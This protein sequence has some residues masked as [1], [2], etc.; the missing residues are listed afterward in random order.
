MQVNA[1]T[2]IQPQGLQASEVGNVDAA[3]TPLV[4][5][6]AGIAAEC[7]TFVSLAIRAS[8]THDTAEADRLEENSDARKKIETSRSH[9]ESMMRTIQ[10]EAADRANQDAPE[11]PIALTL[12]YACQ[13]TLK[14]NTG[15]CADMTL[16]LGA[17]LERVLP[18]RLS[19]AGLNA[20]D[21]ERANPQLRCLYNA[22]DGGNHVVLG[23]TFTDVDAQTE[24]QY[25]ADAWAGGTL[26]PHN[27]ARAFYEDNQ[28]R[29]ITGN[30]QFEE[31]E[32]FS[33]IMKS[34]AFVDAI[35]DTL[36]RQYDVRLEAPM[37]DNP[38]ARYER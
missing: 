27:E 31:N 16:I 24:H 12:Q 3:D 34:P 37:P 33:A 13:Q 10:R 22:E 18:L 15:N 7:T 38:F 5:T 17:V 20:E 1:N 28:S 4:R 35:C 6:I 32:K 8:D 9:H 2:T 36:T 11:N 26:I 14:F 30:F 19:A 25:Y 29:Y 21:I 23:L